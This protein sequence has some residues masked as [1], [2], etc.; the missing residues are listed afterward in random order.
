MITYLRITEGNGNGNMERVG[1]LDK[2]L[3][4]DVDIQISNSF[5]HCNMV[6]EEEVPH[7]L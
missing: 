2:M 1:K 5:S 7:N 4:T 6:R 3:R